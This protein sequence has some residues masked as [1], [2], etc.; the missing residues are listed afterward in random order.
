MSLRGTK[1]SRTIFLQAHVLYGTNITL[2]Y[3]RCFHRA[4]SINYFEL[5]SW[6]HGGA[7]KTPTAGCI[8]IYNIINCINDIYTPLLLFYWRTRTARV[9]S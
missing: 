7:V 2:A 9:I 4:I 5:Y 6:L 3:G 8:D 1:Q